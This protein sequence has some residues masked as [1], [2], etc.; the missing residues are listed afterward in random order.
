MSGYLISW[1]QIK[2]IITLNCCLLLSYATTMNHFSIRL[3]CS[4]VSGFYMTTGDNR[5]VW[6]DTPKHFP[7]P[8]LHQEKKVMVTL[9]VCCLSDPLQ[10]AESQRNHY[11]WEVSSAN[12]WDAPKTA[13]PAAGVG[14]QKGPSS[15][16]QC[17]T[18]HHTTSSSKV[19]WIGLRGFA[20]SAIFTEPPTNWLPLL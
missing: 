4:L 6:E 13:V 3:W 7:K 14:Q 2:K 12:Q 9:V 17:L 15:L 8:N 16:W 19:E 20:S 5:L 10:L 11:I 18:V 1:L